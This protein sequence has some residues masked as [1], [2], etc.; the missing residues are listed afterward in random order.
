MSLI[1]QNKYSFSK[2]KPHSHVETCLNF[3]SL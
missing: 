2:N 3:A 1:I